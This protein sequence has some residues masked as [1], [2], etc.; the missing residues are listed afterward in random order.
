[1]A[2][3]SKA[4]NKQGARKDFNKKKFGKFSGKKNSGVNKNSNASTNPDRTTLNLIEKINE[5]CWTPKGIIGS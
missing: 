2:K 3:R 1:M 4:G 5:S